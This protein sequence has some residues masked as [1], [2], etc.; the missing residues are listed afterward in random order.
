MTKRAL[1]TPNAREMPAPKQCPGA[2]R[3]DSLGRVACQHML[4]LITAGLWRELLET[5]GDLSSPGQAL[6]LLLSLHQPPASVAQSL[7]WKE[8][9]P[10]PCPLENSR[11]GAGMQQE[12]DLAWAL[13]APVTQQGVGHPARA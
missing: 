10:P 8:A 5:I 4:S 11:K 6:H 7:P 1:L 12:N 9:P 13:E 3:N 2:G